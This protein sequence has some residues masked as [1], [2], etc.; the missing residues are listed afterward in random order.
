MSELSRQYD[1]TPFE[2]GTPGSPEAGASGTTNGEQ[3]TSYFAVSEL[4]FSH[5]TYND[6]CI[7]LVGIVA[8]L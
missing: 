3:R 6:A 8:L 7:S 5:K 2:H 4:G 1:V